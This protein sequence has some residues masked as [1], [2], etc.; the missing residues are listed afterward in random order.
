MFCN[1]APIVEQQLVLLLEPFAAQQW[2]L[3]PCYN[4]NYLGALL[5]DRQK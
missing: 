5:D 2:D 4:K 1:I 3:L